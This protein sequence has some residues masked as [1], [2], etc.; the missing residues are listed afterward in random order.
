M[1]I[2]TRA[3]VRYINRLSA[4][5]KKA[6]ELMTQYIQQNGFG[7]TQAII[8][9]AY[10]L[11]SKYGEASVAAACEMYDA[12]SEMEGAILPPAEPADLPSYSEVAKVVNGAKKQ[13]ESL[14]PSAVSRLVKQMG[15][16]TTLQNAQRDGAQFAWIPHGDTCAFCI[17]LASRG[18]QYISKRSLR[19]GHAEHIHANCDCEYA[20]RHNNSTNVAGYDPE[21]YLAEYNE[22]SG[23]KSKD[24]INSMRREL[25]QQNKDAINAQKRAAYANRIKMI[26]AP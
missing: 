26:E 25:Y 10:A 5:N 11:V 3:W 20:I 9:Y 21:E 15:A 17:T 4:V 8:N 12:I 6:G 14:V 24:K 13:S 19:N 7:D 16:D 18:W 22:A 2:S 1:Q 23:E